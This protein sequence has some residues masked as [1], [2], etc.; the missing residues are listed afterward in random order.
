MTRSSN[1][2]LLPKVKV[3]PIS[4]RTCRM[5]NNGSDVL[6]LSF[7]LQER[8]WK[9]EKLQLNLQTFKSV[10]SLKVGSHF[11]LLLSERG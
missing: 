10:G 8:D 7:P 9:L 1:L 3:A 6:S 11:P 5:G 4:H 2:R